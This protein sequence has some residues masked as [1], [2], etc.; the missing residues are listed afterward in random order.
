M[1]STGKIGFYCDVSWVYLIQADTK[2]ADIAQTYLQMYFPKWKTLHFETNCSEKN[3]RISAKC[4]PYG[5]MD[6]T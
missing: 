3:D 2:A 1:K 6:S 5:S 4:V